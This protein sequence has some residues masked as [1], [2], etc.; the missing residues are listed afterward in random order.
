LLQHAAGER[1]VAEHKAVAIAGERKWHIEQ[2]G[3]VDGLGHARAH[4]MLVVLGL[5]HGQ[6]DVGLE[7]QGVVGAQHGGL[8]A[9]CFAAP[10]YHAPGAQGVF[11]VNLVQSVPAGLLHGGANELVAEVAF[12]KIFL[13]QSLALRRR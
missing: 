12:R 9:L 6:R 8:V 7:K 2:L 10:H 3:V 13:V 5:D 4:R 1:G 11:A